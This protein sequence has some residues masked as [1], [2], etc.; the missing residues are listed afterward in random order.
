[1]IPIFFYD[2]SGHKREKMYAELLERREKIS[3][4]AS[5]ADKETMEKIAQEQF[6]VAEINK[7]KKL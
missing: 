5:Q 4:T 1:M 7:N 2:L 6:K 3:K